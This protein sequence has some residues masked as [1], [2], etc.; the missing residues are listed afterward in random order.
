MISRDI[1]NKAIYT[2]SD[3]MVERHTKYLF[4]A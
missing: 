2:H 4:S 1:D 3:R